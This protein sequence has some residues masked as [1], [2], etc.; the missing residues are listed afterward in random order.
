MVWTTNGLWPWRP[1]LLPDETFSSWFARLAA[2]NGLY[3]D[4]LYRLVKPGAHP[5]PRDLD[6]YVEPDLQTTLAERTGVDSE[7]LRQAAFTRW[8]GLVFKEDDN[9]ARAPQDALPDTS[10]P[11][12]HQQLLNI[13]AAGWTSLGAY[14]PV[15]SFVYFRVL[16]LVFRL[17]ATG[18]HADLLRSAFTTLSEQQLGLPCLWHLVAT[19][20]ITADLDCP[21]TMNTVLQTA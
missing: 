4:E 12:R 6:R 8:A 21:L 7:A 17:L 19:G 1:A 16:M 9:F 14:G 5:R 20:R 3:P 2:G 13:T 18:R 15:Y 10:A 11:E